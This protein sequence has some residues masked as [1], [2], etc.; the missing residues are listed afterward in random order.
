MYRGANPGEHLCFS[1]SRY[2]R[3]NLEAAHAWVFGKDLGGHAFS[4]VEMCT[5]LGLD[6]AAVREGARRG[7]VKLNG[8]LIARGKRTARARPDRAWR[9]KRRYRKRSRTRNR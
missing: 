9:A 5:Q 6:P 7:P 3:R 1:T 8:R 4:F 2:D